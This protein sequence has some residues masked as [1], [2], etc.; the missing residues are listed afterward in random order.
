MLTFRM[1]RILVKVCIAD[2]YSFLVVILKPSASAAECHLQYTSVLSKVK[3][4]VEKNN[5]S[6]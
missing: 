4:L 3:L 2:I 5:Y 6:E 1:V